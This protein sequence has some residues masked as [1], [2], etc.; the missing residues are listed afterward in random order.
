[1]RLNLFYNQ[2]A[3]KILEFVSNLS[4][5]EVLQLCKNNFMSRI[6]ANLDMVTTGRKIIDVSTNRPTGVLLDNLYAGAQLQTFIT[7]G[8]SMFGAIPNGFAGC[9]M[10]IRL[11]ENYH[12]GVIPVK[13]FMLL[14]LTHIESCT[15][16]CSQSSSSLMEI[17]CRRGFDGDMVSS[18]IGE[19]STY[20]NQ[21][22][23]N[24]S[25]VVYK[26]TMMRGG[27]VVVM[28]Q[29]PSIG[30][31]R[32][33]N[34]YRFSTEIQM[35]GRIRH[36]HI[37]RLLGFVANR[38]TN[39]LVYEYMPTRF[40]ARQVVEENSGILPREVVSEEVEPRLGLLF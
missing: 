40:E 31:E 9:L 35:L 23:V 1:V 14:N 27:A 10:R 30:V 26:G 2:L 3:D 32:M 29:L 28:K 38:E 4:S 18:W 22:S 6:L 33:H 21:M 24:V 17:W 34:Y 13:L 7:L 36:D 39:L 12:N 25:R 20:N 15:T 8:N 16:T 5:L 37:V 11:G 19:L